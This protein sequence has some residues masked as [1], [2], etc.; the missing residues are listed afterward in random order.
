MPGSS[1][2]AVAG[3]ADAVGV[4]MRVGAGIGS[5]GDGLDE[6]VHAH[7]R[8]GGQLQPGIYR[9]LNW[10]DAEIAP[11]VVSVKLRIDSA[12]FDRSH[13]AGPSYQ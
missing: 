7:R 12:K 5:T 9:L 1:S 8:S 3:G 4:A 2:G 6:A 11:E 10:R 13:S